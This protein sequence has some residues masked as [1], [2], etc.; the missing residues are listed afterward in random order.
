MIGIIFICLF[1]KENSNPVS[2]LGVRY[3]NE[4]ESHILLK[5]ILLDDPSKIHNKPHITKQEVKDTVSDAVGNSF[6]LGLNADYF[7]S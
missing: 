6:C 4:R 3:F 1:P 2:L 5:R 7:I